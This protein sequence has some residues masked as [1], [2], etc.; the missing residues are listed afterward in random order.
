MDSDFL[1]KMG[2]QTICSEWIF[3]F[4]HSVIIKVSN[5]GSRERGGDGENK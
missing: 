4:E 5:A 1:S 3:D 2:I